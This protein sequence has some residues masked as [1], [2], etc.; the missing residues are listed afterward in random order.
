MLMYCRENARRREISC[1]VNKLKIRYL[2]QYWR[3]DDDNSPS[4]CILEIPNVGKTTT[5]LFSSQAAGVAAIL[6]VDDVY[7]QR[8][9]S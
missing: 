1:H 6:P 9:A 8:E 5:A 2:A 7:N 4:V 3:V